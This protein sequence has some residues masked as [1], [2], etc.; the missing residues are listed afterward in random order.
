MADIQV[1]NY[2][3][4]AVG[5]PRAEVL[6]YPDHDGSDIVIE[7]RANKLDGVNF[8]PTG[9]FS[10]R[11]NSNVN[12]TIDQLSGFSFALDADTARNYPAPPDQTIR[13]NGAFGTQVFVFV[14]YPII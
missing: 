11:N 8:I 10:S 14:N 5:T 3:V 12:I 6:V 7:F 4:P 13:I 9:V 1:N 2:L